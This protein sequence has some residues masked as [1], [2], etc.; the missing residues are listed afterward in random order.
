MSSSEP[1]SDSTEKDVIEQE[2]QLQ[3]NPSVSFD[4][5]GRKLVEEEDKARLEESGDFDTNPAVRK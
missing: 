3:N 4:D 1:P 2:I 5:A